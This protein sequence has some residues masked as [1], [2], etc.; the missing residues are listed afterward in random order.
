MSKVK[1]EKYNS[2][3]NSNKVTWKL[4]Y[5]KKDITWLLIGVGVVLVGFLLML[6]GI[7][8]EPSLENG[9]WNN[10]FAVDLAPIVL[11]IGYCVIIPLAL[12]QFFSRSK[13][14]NKKNDTL[15]EQ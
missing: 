14:F 15:N 1:K 6:T 3:K 10:F 8:D 4:P 12:F 11:V 9:A 5:N 7:S 2:R 13:F